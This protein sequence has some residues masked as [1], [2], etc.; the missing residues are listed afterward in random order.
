MQPTTEEKLRILVRARD[1][2]IQTFGRCDEKLFEKAQREILTGGSGNVSQETDREARNEP[3][4][5]RKG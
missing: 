4:S 3:G 2:I 1:A 5:Q